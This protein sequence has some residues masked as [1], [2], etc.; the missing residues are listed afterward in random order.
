MLLLFYYIDLSYLLKDR[1][2]RIRHSRVILFVLLQRLLSASVSDFT[3]AA[4]SRFLLLV[5][6]IPFFSIVTLYS[7]TYGLR[8]AIPFMVYYI[9]SAGIMHFY[10]STY[11][12]SLA[13]TAKA[14]LVRCMNAL[15]EMQ[16]TWGAAARQRELLVGF[17]DAQDLE[18]YGNLDISGMSDNRGRK[19][20]AEN[21]DVESLPGSGRATPY[22]NRATPMDIMA[23]FSNNPPRGPFATASLGQMSAGANIPAQPRRTA[24]QTNQKNQAASKRRH[25]SISAAGLRQSANQAAMQHAPADM[26]INTSV[27]NN[28][29]NIQPSTTPASS[30]AALFPQ[31]D[32]TFVSPPAPSIPLPLPSPSWGKVNGFEFGHAAPLPT[33]TSPSSAFFN[34]ASPPMIPPASEFAS[35]DN[36]HISNILGLTTPN[37]IIN[38]QVNNN[39]NVQTSLEQTMDFG[40]N[41][42]LSGNNTQNQDNTNMFNADNTAFNANQAD[43]GEAPKFGDIAEFLFDPFWQSQMRQMVANS[44]DGSMM[45]NSGA[46]SGLPDLASGPM[47]G[48][49][50]AS[51]LFGG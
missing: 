16:V 27:N 50:Q 24:S 36:P 29:S 33:G 49:T 4:F 10:N 43:S 46:F 47:F 21:Q 30:A 19:R 28:N 23:H 38:T 6:I 25:N 12:E 13:L 22:G 31:G 34:F 20:E 2:E 9:F 15:K 51:D 5:L 40:N 44:N 37:D 32:F 18:I 14:H 11:D 1:R 17:V 41:Q 45:P 48:D 35:H 39:N 7:K 8:Q 3:R 26:R 42:N